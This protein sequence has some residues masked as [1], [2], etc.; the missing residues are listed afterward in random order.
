MKLEQKNIIS[1]FPEVAEGQLGYLN[2]DLNV[3]DKLIIRNQDSSS[4]RYKVYGLSIYDGDNLIESID[5]SDELESEY[6][7][8]V[9]SYE[10]ITGKSIPNNSRVLI[11]LEII[12][13]STAGST[14]AIIHYTVADDN[15]K[16]V[17]YHNT[18]DALNSNPTNYYVEETDVLLSDISR[19]GYKFLG[20]YT[21]PTFE[22]NT[23]VTMINADAPNVLN[24]YARWEKIE[25]TNPNTNSST[26]IGISILSIVIL[27]TILIIVYRIKK[28][29]E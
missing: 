20:W 22:E 9:H 29:S 8:T 17:I 27:S 12:I 25:V 26:Y 2:Y 6:I 23:R 10:E 24:L 21:S 7:Y 18:Y 28:V 1:T 16:E 15:P 14:D 11:N 4:I 19:D 3:G 5:I 13:S